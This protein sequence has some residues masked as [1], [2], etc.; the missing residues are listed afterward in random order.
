M[1]TYS[2]SKDLCT[3]EDFHLVVALEYYEMITKQLEKERQVIWCRGAL[4]PQQDMRLDEIDAEL[5][6]WAEMREEA[7]I[8]NASSE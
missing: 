2:N 8:E 6:Y 1:N 7:L 4:S 3:K 5:T